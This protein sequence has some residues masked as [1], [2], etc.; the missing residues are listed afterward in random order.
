MQSAKRDMM[1]SLG[2]TFGDGNHK[3]TLL[4]LPKHPNQYRRE[5]KEKPILSTLGNMAVHTERL[6]YPRK[7]VRTLDNT[8]PGLPIDSLSSAFYGLESDESDEENHMRPHQIRHKPKVEFAQPK[9][10]AG[11]PSLQKQQVTAGANVGVWACSSLLTGLSI[12]ETTK[13]TKVNSKPTVGDRVHKHVLNK[14]DTCGMLHKKSTNGRLISLREGLSSFLSKNS[15][16]DGDDDASLYRTLKHRM[17]STMPVKLKSTTGMME[18]KLMQNPLPT[19]KDSRKSG[20]GAALQKAYAV[21]GRPYRAHTM[22]DHGNS[23]R[24]IQPQESDLCIAVLRHDDDSDSSSDHHGNL[25]S[26]FQ[27]RLTLSKRTHVVSSEI[28]LVSHHQALEGSKG[29]GMLKMIT[30]P[31]NNLNSKRL[32]FTS[33][34]PKVS[35]QHKRR[36]QKKTPKVKVE[37]TNLA[38]R[39]WEVIDTERD[40][41]VD[42]VIENMGNKVRACND[43]DDTASSLSDDSILENWN[44]PILMSTLMSPHSVKDAT[45]QEEGIQLNG[46]SMTHDT[47]IPLIGEFIDETASSNQIAVDTSDY[48]ERI[49]P[50][51]DTDTVIECQEHSTCL[52]EDPMDV[53]MHEEKNIRRSRRARTA[54]NR[55]TIAAS[56]G[57]PTKK[58]IKRR[59]HVR[60]KPISV[61]NDNPMVADLEGVGSV[62]D[63]Y[64]MNVNS[65]TTKNGHTTGMSQKIDMAVER[66]QRNRKKTDFYH[67]KISLV[68]STNSRVA[69]VTSPLAKSN[70]ANSIGACIPDPGVPDAH[71]PAPKK[72]YTKNGETKNATISKPQVVQSQRV[73]VPK[74]EMIDSAS[75]TMEEGWS[76]D[77]LEQL[78]DAQLDVDPTSTSYWMDVATIVSG[79]S[80]SECQAKWFSMTKTPAPKS[81]SARVV[82]VPVHIDDLNEDEDDIFQSTPM[83]G[84]M[85]LT[86]NYF[87]SFPSV[88]MPTLPTPSVLPVDAE[89]EIFVPSLDIFVPKVKPVSK[90]FLQRMKRNFAKAE[91]NNTTK[92]KTL[93]NRSSKNTKAL[94][95][96]LRDHDMD[97]NIRLSPGGTLQVKS[98]VDQGDE[99]DFWDDEYDAD[100]ENDERANYC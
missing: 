46:E 80:A 82:V 42:V 96:V 37:S 15:D 35:R 38:E 86:S 98:H 78:R 8:R 93:Q 22:N 20:N 69:V 41:M 5:M 67:N 39:N 18:K 23:T 60:S 50:P 61:S 95:E 17:T 48:L 64:P 94:T 74:T 28:G 66:P 13:P 97:I 57:L 62:N 27:S 47:E 79:K 54:T 81:K 30:E 52:S 24:R 40:P 3:S 99:D 14:I 70:V 31:E 11:E 100:E 21:A 87:Q 92:T 12:R 51:L 91:A 63:S 71:H 45:I 68:E 4:Q 26:L 58:E 55:F 32:I 25:L 65:S 33:P 76:M 10:Y 56:D 1:E 59:S 90:A 16:G 34:M 2:S 83:R 72:E 43:D 53:S 49:M 77:Q 7:N 44:H 6:N 75:V 73:I 89:N 19:A 88:N 9:Q 85:F 84:N 29:T 36:D